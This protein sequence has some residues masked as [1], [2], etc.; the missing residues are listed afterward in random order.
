M[1]KKILIGISGA[2][3]AVYGMRLLQVLRGIETIDSHLI[4]S[5]PAKIVIQEE[6]DFTIGEVE[7][8]AD[9]VYDTY[10]LAA[11]VSSGSF[12]TG[13]MIVAPCSVKT[14]SA[15]ANSYADNLLTR[16]CD[17]TLKQK[18]MLVLVFRETPLHRG[19]K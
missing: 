15:V 14:L 1:N 11:P 6:S 2:S 13:G 7:Q 18:R 19:H 12:E 8:L 5:D 17:V 16:A 10:N 4:I 9:V 3:G